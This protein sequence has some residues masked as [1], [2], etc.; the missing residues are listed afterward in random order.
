MAS[1]TNN[2]GD[3]GGTCHAM[4]LDGSMKSVYQVV[5][6]NIDADTSKSYTNE[7]QFWHLIFV[8]L[9]SFIDNWNV[10]I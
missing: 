6:A 2:T 8:H 7:N 1:D 9:I 10:F 4:D 5:P 3:A